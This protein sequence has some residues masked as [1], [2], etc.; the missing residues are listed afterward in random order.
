VPL[1]VT[2]KFVVVFVRHVRLDGC[3]VITGGWQVNIPIEAFPANNPFP[4]NSAVPCEADAHADK[5][6]MAVRRDLIA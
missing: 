4:L 3:T 1:A 5:H 2:V 6:A